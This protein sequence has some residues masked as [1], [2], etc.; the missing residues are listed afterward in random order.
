MS[1]YTFKALSTLTVSNAQS[2]LIE[3]CKKVGIYEDFGSEVIRHLK[4]KYKYNPY[5]HE[6][7]DK[8]ICSKI[9]SLDKW[10]WNYNG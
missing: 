5:S 7:K 8:A 9:D 2:K 1:K 4:N 3:H 6:P 10:T